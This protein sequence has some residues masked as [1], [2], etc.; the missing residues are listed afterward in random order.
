MTFGHL[1]FSTEALEPHSFGRWIAPSVLGTRY[2]M[3]HHHSYFI[4][5]VTILHRLPSLL[6][7]PTGPSPFDFAAL[8]SSNFFTSRVVISNL[9]VCV[10]VCLIFII[11]SYFSLILF[12]FCY[13][14]NFIF[15]VFS[16]P[17]LFF[18]P[19]FFFSLSLLCSVSQS[20]CFLAY[21]LSF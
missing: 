20:L 2:A 11:F 16:S 1:F 14:S 3:H 21:T 19:I 8:I 17:L 9:C 13:R 15:F 12:F 10:I 5:T 7:S 4:H 6:V 18:F